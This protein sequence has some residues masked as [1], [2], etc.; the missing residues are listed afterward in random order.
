MLPHGFLINS[1]ELFGIGL[2]EFLVFRKVEEFS[3]KKIK[4][5]FPSQNFFNEETDPS[6]CPDHISVGIIELWR[7][8]T[9]LWIF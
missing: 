9:K 2:I 4:I 7:F 8:F 3:L 5:F 6:W 1:C